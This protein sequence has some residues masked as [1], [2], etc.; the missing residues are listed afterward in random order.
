MSTLQD[1]LAE[2]SQDRRTAVMARCDELIA[3]EVERIEA[4]ADV[5]EDQ[6]LAQIVC[7]REKSKSVRVTLDEL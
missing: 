3:E 6:E 4:I 2:L 1:K 7:D 5:L